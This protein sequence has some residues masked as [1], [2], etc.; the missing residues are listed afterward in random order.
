MMRPS[1]QTLVA[2]LAALLVVSGC[3]STQE[4]RIA[5][6]LSD[7]GLPSGLSGCMADRMVENLSGSQLRRVAD[8][9]DGLDRDIDRMTVGEIASRFGGIGDS[10]IVS[11]MGRAAAG[12]VISG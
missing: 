3:A 12:C 8:F 2:S 4:R 7:L 6:G 5:S 9:A 10:E 1:R 11:V